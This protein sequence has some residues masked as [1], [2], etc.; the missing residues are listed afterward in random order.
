MTKL[1]WR[2]LALAALALLPL[3]PVAAQDSDDAEIRGVIGVYF[4]GHATGNADTMRMA[5]LPTA[6]IEGIRN[7]AFSSWTVE[8][9]LAGFRGTPAADEATRVRTIDAI[10]R[11]GTAAMARAISPSLAADRPVSA[12]PCT[13]ATLTAAPAAVKSR[14]MH[15]M[16]RPAQFV[17]GRCPRSAA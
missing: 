9:Y 8:Q 11:S 5:F 16:A 17:G 4:R 10:D 13:S 7:G 3:A 15:G 6:H 14:V 1:F 2:P 12:L